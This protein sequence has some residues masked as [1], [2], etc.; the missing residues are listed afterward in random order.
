MPV[1]VW[2][3]HRDGREPHASPQEGQDLAFVRSW[4][5]CGLSVAGKCVLQGHS[6]CSRAWNSLSGD[7]WQNYGGSVSLAV[8]RTGLQGGVEFV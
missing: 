4:H 6:I 5:L 1:R 2:E 8:A 7:F 3:R